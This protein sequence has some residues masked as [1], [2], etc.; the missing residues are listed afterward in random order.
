MV[1]FETLRTRVEVYGSSIQLVEEFQLMKKLQKLEDEH[2]TVVGL[3]NEVWQLL[4][5]FEMFLRRKGYKTITFVENFIDEE[6]VK[7]FVPPP[8]SGADGVLVS[9]DIIGKR[10]FDEIDVEEI[11][12][13]IT[14]IPPPPADRGLAKIFLLHAYNYLRHLAASNSL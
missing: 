11:E 14:D 9:M 4:G 1:E 10:D 3:L 7:L 8:E 6:Y 12:I 13:I 5:A 2:Q